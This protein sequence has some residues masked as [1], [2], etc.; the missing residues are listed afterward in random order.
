[1]QQMYGFNKASDLTIFIFT[2]LFCQ[3]IKIESTYNT[4]ICRTVLVGMGA[5]WPRSSYFFQIRNGL[6]SSC[7]DSAKPCIGASI[8][9]FA[10][11]PHQCSVEAVDPVCQCGSHRAD[12]GWKSLVDMQGQIQGSGSPRRFYLFAIQIAP[13]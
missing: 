1:M 11:G 13:E 6:G 8:L 9:Q 3:A 7:K 12:I 2:C 4:A 5:C 10:V